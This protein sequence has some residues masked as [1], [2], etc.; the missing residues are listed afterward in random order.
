LI[1]NAGIT[2]PVKF[3]EIAQRLGSH[4]DVNLKG[5][6]LLSQVVIRICR[7]ARLDRSHAYVGPRS[8]AAYFRDALLR[9]KGWRA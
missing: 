6:L 1:N 4:Q 9:G 3:L 2:Q 7:S 5:I 8:A